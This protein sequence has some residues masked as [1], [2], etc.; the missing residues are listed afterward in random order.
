MAYTLGGELL[1]S[2]SFVVAV[3]LAIRGGRRGE[4]PGTIAL[5]SAAILYAAVVVA[6]TV[7]PVTFARP[8]F[9]MASDPNWRNSV[10]VVPLKTIALYTRTLLAYA[11]DPTS[12]LAAIARRNLL[13][14]LALLLPVGVIAPLVWRRLDGWAQV[15]LAGAGVSL[16]IE[17]L[18]FGRTY[19]FGMPGRSVDI[20]DVI[21]N[22][23]GALLGYAIYRI[24]RSISLRTRSVRACG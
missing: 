13:G 14:N 15:L 2:L 17:G 4:R 21:L 10:N 18:Q 24:V 11:S 5:R 19:V 12:Q 8:E 9:S 6:L 3:A 23:A 20:D 1:V 22:T 7:L 16:L